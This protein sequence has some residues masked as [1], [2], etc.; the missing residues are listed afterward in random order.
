MARTVISA[1]CLTAFAVILAMVALSE[2]KPQFAGGGRIRGFFNNLSGFNDPELRDEGERSGD[3]DEDTGDGPADDDPTGDAGDN[4]QE[5]GL[6]PI[7]DGPEP[8]DDADYEDD[9]PDGEAEYA[10]EAGER[11]NRQY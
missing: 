7:N 11:D 6:Q 4:Q 9:G 5:Q 8:N 10:D 3:A 1:K 2:A